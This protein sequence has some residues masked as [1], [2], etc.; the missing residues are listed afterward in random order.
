MKLASIENDKNQ[1]HLAVV[2]DQ[3]LLLDLY[4]LRSFLPQANLIPENMKDLLAGGADVL[5]K[6]LDCLEEIR[7]LILKD[8]E[9]EALKQSNILLNW[10]EVSFLPP[11]PD[12][13]II[14][15]V[16]MN[17]H[18]HLKEMQNA[19]A[20]PY[21]PAFLMTHQALNGSGKPIV[22]PPQCPDMIDFEGELCFVFGK[23]CYD[24]S[25]NEAMDYVAGYTIANDVSARDWVAPV[26]KAEKPFEGISAWDRNLLGKQ[27]PTF[28]PCGPVIVTKD[29]I[30]DPHN[31]QLTL[32]L[33]GK[34]MQSS[35]TDD[36][37]FN[38]P[39]IISYFS[40]WYR[41]S[42]G[43][44]VTTGSPPGVGAGRNPPVY[45]KS[46]DLVEVEIEGIGKLSNPVS[47]S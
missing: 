29:E 36:L 13:T 12:P 35:R 40:K 24:V 45:M 5:T 9:R 26:F 16:G 15:S 25:E 2:F 39:Q 11:V 20:L 41:F 47:N 18:A 27:L 44:I 34:V 8:N 19:P 14:L 4:E 28:C 7:L 46:G 3:D 37:I 22:V 17:Y 33:N 38:L 21:P 23:Y 1:I 10:D 43:D 32:T 6:I 30:P 42:P 31:L